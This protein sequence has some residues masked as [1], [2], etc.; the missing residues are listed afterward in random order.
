MK[1]K[2]GK[3][4][5]FYHWQIVINFST[6]I[7]GVYDERLKEAVKVYNLY[8]DPE[9]WDWMFINCNKKVD[10]PSYFYSTEGIELIQKSKR[11]MKYNPKRPLTNIKLGDKVGEDKKIKKKNNLIN[12][13]GK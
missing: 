2:N 5:E 1:I 6:F 10:S 3:T 4:P 9:F 11:L 8:P 12:F 7:K 13:I